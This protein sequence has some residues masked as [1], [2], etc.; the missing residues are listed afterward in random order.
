M[1]AELVERTTRTVSLG[2]DSGIVWRPVPGLAPL[3]HFLAWREGDERNA[4]R[5]LVDACR[6]A[7]EVPVS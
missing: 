5:D 6:E 4:V 2:E 1:G 3:E 7:F